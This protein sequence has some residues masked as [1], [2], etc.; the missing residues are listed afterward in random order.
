VAEL[1][2]EEHLAGGLQNEGEVEDGD[3]CAGEAAGDAVFYAAA[4]QH[5][6]FVDEVVQDHAGE[7]VDGADWDDLD[8]QEG[9]PDGFYYL[10]VAFAHVIG[11]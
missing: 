4:V 5:D 9:E 10:S 8:V 2:V 7:A 6:V 1:R 3:H 11:G